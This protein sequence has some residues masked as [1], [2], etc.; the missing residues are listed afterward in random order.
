[1][2]R[3][4]DADAQ[5]DGSLNALR[6]CPHAVSTEVARDILRR[7][8]AHVASL[9]LPGTTRHRC[10]SLHSRLPSLRFC[11]AVPRGERLP[12]PPPALEASCGVPKRSGG[13]GAPPSPE[14]GWLRGAASRRRRDARSSP[15]LACSATQA[16]ALQEL[17][18]LA[19]LP[20]ASR[21]FVERTGRCR[22]LRVPGLRLD[23]C[24]LWLARPCQLSLA[25][26]RHSYCGATG[27]SDAIAT[28]KP[29][30]KPT[31]PEA[32][33]ALADSLPLGLVPEI[34]L[35]VGGHAA[36]LDDS[37]PNH[38]L[39]SAQLLSPIA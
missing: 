17:V 28:P 35:Y 23:P 36:H 32:L 6:R 25:E 16:P 7:I 38:V 19:A 14:T 34:A 8:A 1:M 37:G 15:S 24:G 18:A 20:P 13:W 2:D 11:S 12:V 33:L 5:G 22:Q 10:G 39:V 26:R 31:P 4:R 3:L 29:T 9:V 21:P 27:A 30:P